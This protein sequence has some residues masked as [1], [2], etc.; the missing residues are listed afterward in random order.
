[1][2]FCFPLW[3][4]KP[5]SALCKYADRLHFCYIACTP[6]DVTTSGRLFVKLGYTHIDPGYVHELVGYIEGKSVDMD[7]YDNPNAGIYLFPMS[8]RFK[9]F[10][11][12]EFSA[13][14]SMEEVF[15]SMSAAVTSNARKVENPHGASREWWLVGK[16]DESIYT[17]YQRLQ[18]N[19][20]NFS[21]VP[22]LPFQATRGS[23][24]CERR[25]WEWLTWPWDCAFHCWWF[26]LAL[27]VY[28]CDFHCTPDDPR[29]K[30]RR[31][32]LLMKWRAN[33]TP[34]DAPYTFVYDFSCL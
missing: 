21:D 26:D 22:V 24:G 1:M 5:C 9:V 15:D 27:D 14:E 32:G 7:L 12:P 16:A 10:Q 20:H 11:R 17:T 30:L 3:A 33:D 6:A 2:F 23:G 8:D 34:G 28:N 31:A 25:G 13:E 4:W 29:C 18:W 19:I